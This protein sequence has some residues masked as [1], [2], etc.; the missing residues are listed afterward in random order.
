MHS[1]RSPFPFAQKFGLVA[2]AALLAACSTSSDHRA[3][4]GARLS[5]AQPATLAGGCD[6]LAGKLAG[7]AH[8]RV[9]SV[10]AVAKDEL[11]AGATP[12]PEHCLVTGAMHER[13]GTDGKTPYAIGFEMRLPID[14][15]GRFFYQGNG[16]ID[17]A[18]P[19]S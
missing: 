1:G 15:N 2:A 13:T 7:L 5:V 18:G 19:R 6:T 16:G 14:W 11:K 3:P 10:K 12:V 8:T 9:L 17:G 4:S